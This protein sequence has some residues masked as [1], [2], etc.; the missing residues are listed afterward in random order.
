MGRCRGGAL[1]RGPPEGLQR[2]WYVQAAGLGLSGV[3]GGALSR[4]RCHISLSRLRPA[5]T[6]SGGRAPGGF[7]VGWVALVVT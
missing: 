1:G 7:R 5:P 3:V 4:R 2:N 6:A